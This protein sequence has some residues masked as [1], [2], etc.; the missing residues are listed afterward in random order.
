MKHEKLRQ[1][2]LAAIFIALILLMS[3]TPLGYL[4]VGVLSITLIPI[5]VIIGAIV[6]GP[7][8]GALFGLV[9][10]LTSF[11]Q[12]FMGDAFGALLVSVSPI[13]AFIMCVV[14]RVFVGLVPGLLFRLLTKNP[15]HGRSV[16]AFVSALSGPLTNTVLFLGMLGLLFDNTV[17]KDMRGETPLLLFLVLTAGINAVIEML[18][19]AVIA[20]PIYFALQP[21]KVVLGIDLGASGTKLALVRHKKVLRTMYAEKS[22]PLESVLNRFG[23][24]GCDHIAVTGVGASYITGDLMGKRTVHVDEFAS[25]YRGASAVAKSYNMVIASVGTGTSFVRVTPFGARHLGGSGVGGGMLAGLGEKLFGITDAKALR[26]LAEQGDTANCDL[27]LRDICDG[28]ISNL[29]PDTTVANLQKAAKA[30]DASNARGLYNLIFQSVGVMAAFATKSHLTRKIFVC[31]AIL[32]SH[33]L[34]KEVFEGVA[35]LHKVK[36]IIP[37]NA[38]YITAIGATLQ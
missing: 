1:L 27:Q 8:Y 25:L 11:A 4:R 30:D 2:V 28:T 14:T 34:A 23:L 29:K 26:A 21:H 38:A 7:A 5:P 10:G 12:C 16:A 31:G 13:G 18:A 33:S 6:L 36:F 20:P 17:L 35:G 19:S 37:E 9:F 24:E 15:L 3:F 32:D 22:E